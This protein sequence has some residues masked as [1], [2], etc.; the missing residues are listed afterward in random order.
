MS[1]NLLQAGLD[2]LGQ[3]ATSAIT[4][5]PTP[6]S[7][8]D[9]RQQI[10]SANLSRQLEEAKKQREGESLEEYAKRLQVGNDAL[11]TYRKAENAIG[12][13]QALGMLPIRDQLGQI[14]AK[15]KRGETQ[16]EISLNDAKAQRQRELLGDI[17]SHEYRLAGGSDADARRDVL[18][19]LAE[20]RDLNLAAQREANSFGKQ[21]PRLLPAL[22]ASALALA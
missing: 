13:D 22:L 4:G 11:L 8:E 20:S 17:A 5:K 2:R 9:L 14:I 6:G 18:A 15:E 12:A 10:I 7:T 21:I 3:A 1:S 19:Y 16:N